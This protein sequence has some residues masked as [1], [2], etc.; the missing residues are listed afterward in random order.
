MKGKVYLVG[1]GP[2][3]PKLITLR[4]LEAIRKAS[5]IVY[6]RLANPRLLD[7]ARDDAE[8]IYVGKRPDRHT[9]AQE[10]INR[11][12][13]DLAIQGKTV[14]RLKGGDPSVF[15]RVG[16][17]ASELAEAGIAFEIVPGVTSATAVPAYAGIPV[18]YREF[19]TAFTVITGHEK[20]EKL[21]S[22]IH[23][24]KLAV[25]DHTLIFLMGVAKIGHISEQLMR[26][27]ASPDMPVA[28]VRWGTR[29]EQATLTGTLK[30]IAVKVKEADF[31][32]PAVIVVGEVVKLRERLQWFEKKPLFGKRVLVTRSRS[33]ASELVEQI[34]ALGGEAVQFP[35]IRFEEPSDPAK[36]QQLDEA[37]LNA[38]SFDWIVFTSVNGVQFFFRRMQHLR[39][40]LRQLG[41]I[42]IA[43][44]GTKTQEALEERGLYADV[45]PATFDAEHLLEAL[46]PQLSTGE[47]ILLPRADI[48]RQVLPETLRSA[49]MDVCEV[50]VYENKPCDDAA[51]EVVEML[52]RRECHAV[53]FTSSSTVRR[54]MSILERYGE[55][56]SELLAGVVIACIGPLTVAAANEY[57]MAADV[58]PEDATVEALTAALAE[59]FTLRT[60]SQAE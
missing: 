5:V 55:Q 44:V 45:V 53:T 49:G 10:D 38:G 6:D 35:V 4:G 19:N 60:L 20:T 28:L 36:R 8:R 11:L 42:R 54:L 46:L 37:V 3:D 30:D 25:I 22:M 47:R 23:W 33:Q 2:G 24:E 18:T 13:V 40:D 12:L 26:H 59:Y 27:G 17:E 43:A 34:D 7:H 14:V 51:D 16:E 41:T 1:A 21:D 32:P 58:V 48:G 57:G 31:Q 50:D 39:V 29:A 15:G 56:P 52:R 9:M